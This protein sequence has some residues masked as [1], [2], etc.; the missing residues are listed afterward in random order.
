MEII[1]LFLSLKY[2]GEWIAIYD[3]LQKREKLIEQEVIKAIK[4]VKSNFLTLLDQN[5]CAN[6]KTIYR[7]PFGIYYVGNFN[8]TKSK[9]ISLIGKLRETNKKY[10]DLIF[11][12]NNAII[13]SYLTKKEIINVLQHYPK[14]NIFYQLD[15]AKNY[16][17][18]HKEKFADLLMKNVFIS[19]IWEINDTIDYS[20]QLNERLFCGIS[21]KILIIDDINDKNI[22]SLTNFVNNEEISVNILKNIYLKKPKKFKNIKRLKIINDFEEMKILMK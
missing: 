10:I 12:K 7:P 20:N 13:W 5:Y 11:N 22:S 2:H 21:K 8:L 4:K 19:E 1:L 17:L 3:S 6:L 15:L 9:S 14:N 16:F 18:L